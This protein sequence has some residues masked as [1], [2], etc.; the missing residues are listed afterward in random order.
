MP[1]WAQIT[2]VNAIV[3]TAGQSSVAKALDLGSL[4]AG[5]AA[6]TFS[7][8]WAMSSL[9]RLSACRLTL[10]VKYLTRSGQSAQAVLVSDLTSLRDRDPL[11]FCLYL[12]WLVA[13]PR[14]SGVITEGIS[15]YITDGWRCGCGVFCI[16]L[17]VLSA[18]VIGTMFW[19][20]RRAKEHGASTI[21]I[22]DVGGILLV[23]FPL[24]EWR[25]LPQ[26]DDYGNILAVRDRRP[27]FCRRPYGRHLVVYKNVGMAPLPQY[28]HPQLATVDE[29]YGSIVVARITE[30]RELV[31]QSYLETGY[32]LFLPTLILS[33]TLL[34][35]HSLV[36][37]HQLDERHNVIED[38]AVHIG[39][40]PATPGQMTITLQPSLVG[41]SLCC[42]GYMNTG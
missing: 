16:V 40:K 22:F 38:E 10:G 41:G 42:G 17:L 33:F 7:S 34:L 39:G 18:P 26:L 12:P 23:A 27:D 37:D 2:I 15:A 11:Q 21:V 32:K 4:P 20:D 36:R 6:G 35:F 30:P 28:L 1:C 5:Y 14:C 3:T 9:P 31:I 13:S 24:Y 29:V 19:G 8:S 25:V